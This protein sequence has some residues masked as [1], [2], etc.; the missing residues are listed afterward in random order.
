MDFDGVRVL[1]VGDV[2]LDRYVSG[3]V[4]RISPEAPVPVVAVRRRW[5]VPGGAAN[6]ARN[7]LRLGV[8]AR[9]TGLAGR[10][11]DGEEL[12][13]AL[14]AEGLKD[15]LVYAPA[16]RTTCKTRVLAQGQQMLRLDEELCAP[17][18]AAELAALR[19]R[20]LELLPGCGA[21][22]L[23]DYGKGVLLPDADGVS[24]CAAVTEAAEA[25]GVPVLVDPK[26]GQWERY[27]GA[28]CVTP[29]SAEF[30]RACGEDAGAAPDA[31]RRAALAARLCGDYAFAR[32]LLTRGA[33]GMEL[34]TGQG[35]LCRCPARAREVADVSGAGDTVVAVLAACVAKGLPWEESVRV[36]NTAAG[37]VVGKT[38][39]APVT[40]SELRAA[41]RENAENPK[42]FALPDLL[43]KVEDWRRKNETVVFTNGCFDLLHPGHVSLLRQSAAQGDHLIVG[44][45]SDAS[46][47]RLKGPTRPIQDE[48]SRAQVLAALNGV[49]AVILFDADTPLELIRAI[50]PDVLVKG[51]DYTE[52][53]VVGADLV[54]AAGGRV[55]LAALTPGC[56]TTGI[57][58]KIDAGPQDG[59][60]GN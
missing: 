37:V 15:S 4:R 31:A 55:F 30:M 28:Q 24:L 49:E 7:L 3:S 60:P 22:V 12:R 26:G 51:S 8:T 5:S 34:Y 43:E 27:R 9:L 23:S 1:V 20:A 16:R 19:E 14:A 42:L 45:N 59:E 18:A 36:A 21:V 56:S 10:D 53:T 25:L 17:P 48:R 52:A 47:R 2:M 6:V 46:V 33:K 57:V 11:A 13:A 58:R 44:L 54:R 38:G 32:V 39:T 40:L 50:R 29:N 35:L 41:L